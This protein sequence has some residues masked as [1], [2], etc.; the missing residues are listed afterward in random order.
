MGSAANCGRCGVTRALG[1][2]RLVLC[3]SEVLTLAPK[4]SYTH[5]SRTRFLTP[6][7]SWRRKVGLALGGPTSPT[8][9]FL[10]PAPTLTCNRAA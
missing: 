2:G 3:Q 6:G 9:V 8:W 4:G 1:T 7:H 5:P 10:G